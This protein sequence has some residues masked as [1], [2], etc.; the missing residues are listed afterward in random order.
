MSDGVGR[1]TIPTP[2]GGELVSQELTPQSIEQAAESYDA[3]SLQILKGLEAVR[4]RPAMYIGTTGW[5]GMH[6]LFVEIVDNSIDEALGGFCRNIQVIINPDN[7]MTVVDDG[8]GFPVDT[9]SETGLPG[10]EVALTML[11]AGGKF[12]QEHSAY[13]V[14]GG[15]HGVGAS[16]VNA[17]SEWLEVEVRRNGKIY[18]QRFERGEKV[19]ELEVI[20]KTKS[21]GTTITFLPDAEIFDTTEWHLDFI[22]ERLR[23][24]AFLNPQVKITFHDRRSPN[25]P[26]VFDNKGGLVAFVEYLNR[27]KDPEHKPIYFS[28]ERDGVQVEVAIQYNQGYQENIVSYANNI[29]TADG[30]THVSGFK[31]ALTRVVNQYARKM[32]LLKEK[33]PN[34]QGED[35]REGLT[36]VI[37]V[38]LP[39]PQFEAQT[40]GKLGN[41]EIEGLMNSVTGEALAE[42]MEEN[43]TIAR[44]IVDKALTS[45]KAREAARRASELVKR[46]SALEN[47]SLPGKLADCTERDPSKCELFLVEGDSAGG[48]AKNGRDRKHQAVLP[49]RGKVI[50]VE[51]V[52]LHRALENEEIRAL[53]TAL[54]TGIVTEELD[55]DSNGS[56]GNGYNGNANGND[57]SSRFD[58]NKLRYHR[59]IIMTDADIDGAHI[60]IL[61]LTFFFR[62]MRP[63]IE[64]GHVYIA[65][66][67][68]YEIRSGRQVRYA[69]DDKERDRI[70]KEISSRNV[71]IRRFKGLGE[72]N[73]EQLADTTMDVNQ[74]VV[75][76]VSFEDAVMADSI[77]SAL[78][79]DKV[80]P[81][82]EFIEAHAREAK[83]LDI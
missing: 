18:H 64:A 78:M 76:R 8:R 79:G 21:H 28:R 58:I 17:L 77:F 40:K 13:K 54:G 14:S 43:P 36:A 10:V 32:G 70:L 69:F 49:L 47:A 81:R 27:N 39:H 56:N 24:L 22:T 42:F 9:N 38:R 35:T 67:P 29:N 46:Q 60:R 45:A 48:S 4:R 52:R 12:N 72:M 3:D 82:K 74:R 50:N 61:L 30:G 44:R 25:E 41:S 5:R 6:H 31:T 51:K 55:P 68:L 65:Q 75:L 15:L 57:K 63:L 23:E 34:F 53:I 20:G 62:Y 26:V 33:D 80:P 1:H 83:D 59:I 19:K 66:P 7:S 11:H 73:A 2:S 71:S 37:S 16:C